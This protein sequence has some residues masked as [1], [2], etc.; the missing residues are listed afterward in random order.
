M[1]VYQDE[2]SVNTDEL[3]P[4]DASFSKGYYTKKV[5]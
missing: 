3:L 5:N 1:L 4:Q 2:E